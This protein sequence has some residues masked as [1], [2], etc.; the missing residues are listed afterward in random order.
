MGLDA[1]RSSISY[2]LI[3]PA[4]AMVTMAPAPSAAAC[5]ALTVISYTSP[6]THILRPPA[7]LD[8]ASI[9]PY[10]ILSKPSLFLRSSTAPSRP[11]RT[12]PS[13]TLV[14]AWPWPMNLGSSVLMP[15]K[16]LTSVVVDPISATRTSI[17]IRTCHRIK[18]HAALYGRRVLFS[19][20]H[21][22]FTPVY[23]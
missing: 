16:A 18:P 3:L 2:S 21:I 17:F 10:S 7:A 20:L 8:V 12:S 15:A 9:S 5:A 14:G 11:M 22:L 1:T 19:P 23:S 13:S 6:C 4:V